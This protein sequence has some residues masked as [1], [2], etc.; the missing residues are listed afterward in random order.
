MSN[1]KTLNKIILS[2]KDTVDELRSDSIIPK[3]NNTRTKHFS[4]L[5]DMT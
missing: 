3:A 5:V 4:S 2:N 1:L